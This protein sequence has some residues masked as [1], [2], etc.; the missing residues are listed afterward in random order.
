MSFRKFTING[1]E[2]YEDDNDVK[3][4]LLRHLQA[5]KHVRIHWRGCSESARLLKNGT[6]KAL[7]RVGGRD[8]AEPFIYED[9]DAWFAGSIIEEEALD[10]EVNRMEEAMV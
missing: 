8:L 2:S 5:R 9:V 6:I 10:I 4:F 3:E 1:E 7:G